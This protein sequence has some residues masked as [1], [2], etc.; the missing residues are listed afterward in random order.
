MKTNRNAAH[1]VRSAVEASRSR[2]G[3]ARSTGQ[4]PRSRQGAALAILALAMTAAVAVL[5]TGAA[6]WLHGVPF[7]DPS[8]LVVLTGTFTEHGAVAEWPIGQVDF[9]DWRR[10]A[11]SFAAMSVSNPD[12]DLALNLEG[13]AE[14]ERLKGE[15]VSADY[16]PLLGVAPERGRFFSRAEDSRPFTDYVVVLGHDLWRRR[17]GGDPGVVGRIVTLNGQRYRVVGI[18]PAGFH[19]LPDSTDLWIPSQLPPIPEYVNERLVRWVSVVAR[20]APGVSVAQ[21]QREMDRIT[22]ELAR[23]H[24][25]TN[26]GM[27]VRVARLADSLHGEMRHALLLLALGAA[28]ALLLAGLDVGFLLGAGGDRRGRALLPVLLPLALAGTLVALLLGPWVVRALLAAGGRQLQSWVHVSSWRPEVLAAALAAAAGAC[29]CAMAAAAAGVRFRRAAV[30]AQA[31]AAALLLAATGVR[32]GAFLRQTHADLGFRPGRLLTC[33][34]DIR[35]PR[36]DELQPV[37]DVVRKILQR[38]P[39]E[40]PGVARLALADPTIPTDGWAGTYISIEG[41]PSDS[42][43]GTYPSMVHSVTADYFALLGIRLVAGRGFGS[44]EW[45]PNGVVVSQA[46]AARYWPGQSALGK[47]LKNG[48]A[49]TKDPWLTVLGVAGDVRHEGIGGAARPASDVYFPLTQFPMRLPLTVN[50]LVLPRPGT[51]T[52]GLVAGL[53][54][55]MRAISPDL[56]L[57]DVA[58]LQ[59]RVDRQIRAARLPVLLVGAFAALTLVLAAAGGLALRR[60]GAV[61][62]GEEPA[63]ARGEGLSRLAAVP[64]AEDA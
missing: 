22:A 25:D 29:A 44:G 30:G 32:A 46:T 27:G 45:L 56:P 26:R 16:F 51:A 64:G 7:R 54:R 13:V 38:V 43:Q 36:W 31:A 10:L 55:E 42:P 57:F 28:G 33:R 19:G 1:E 3:A 21:A 62:E 18:A 63:A 40:V 5:A 47:R 2:Q 41:H 59:E 49:S 48:R 17:F 24:P 35:G 60:A 34:L 61:R 14:P 6:V 52:A 58:T 37:R 12:G 4:P 9:A 8:R 11:R 39:A 23:Q 50:F 15:L 20:L 53:R